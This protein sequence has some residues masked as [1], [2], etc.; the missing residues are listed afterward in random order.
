[1]TL[2]NWRKRKGH[3]YTKLAELLGASHATVARRWCRPF[4]ASDRKVP[5]AAY[6]DRIIILT[7]GAVTPNDFYIQRD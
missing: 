6:M 2:D 7:E 1:M 3:S 5:N 4:G